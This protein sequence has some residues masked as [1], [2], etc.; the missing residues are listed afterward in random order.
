MSGAS[1][2][3]VAVEPLPDG[4]GEHRCTCE[5]CTCTAG[6]PGKPH[7]CTCAPGGA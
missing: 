5:T 4:E 6:D 2:I 3:T 1:V 7:R